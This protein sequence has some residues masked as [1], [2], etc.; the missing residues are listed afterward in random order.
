MKEISIIIATYNASKTISSCLNSIIAQKEQST[1]LIIIDGLSSDSTQ[2]IIQT[3][4]NDIDV[5]ISE[6]DFGVYDAWNK[7]IS[8]SKGNWIMFV[9]ADDILLPN[10]IKEI[11]QFIATNN[12]SETDYIS[13]KNIYTDENGKFLKIIGEEYSWNK[14]KKGMCV[15]HVASLHNRK[16]F[17][18]IGLYSLTYKICADYD[19]LLRKKNKI[20]TLFINKEIAKMQIG[21]M[22]F[23]TN[24]LKEVFKIRSAHTTQSVFNNRLLFMKDLILFYTF[25]PRKNLFN[26]LNNFRKG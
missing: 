12:V 18:E 5:F 2:E 26:L 24:A 23:S 3:Y 25:R 4:G 15:A 21:G 11:L 20:N 16:L 6:N 9:G 10:S 7:G 22:S 19:L 1:E 14:M 8:V 13:A 17:D